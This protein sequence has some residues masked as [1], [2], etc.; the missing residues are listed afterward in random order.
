MSSR[1]V[2]TAPPEPTVADLDGI[3]RQ[4]T[5][6]WTSRVTVRREYP[7]TDIGL[8][9]I[10]VSLNGEW[11]GQLSPGQEVSREVPPGPH[12]LRV[13]N[14][15]F[16]KTA[17]FTVKVGEEASFIASNR[18]GLG[19]YSVFAFFLGGMPIYL[20]LEREGCPDGQS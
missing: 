5:A 9:E 14:T 19:T 7:P 15:L 18:E 10:H 20:T 8:R 3:V 1:V 6:S 17:E 16:W 4:L 12:R 2:T 11:L 13:N